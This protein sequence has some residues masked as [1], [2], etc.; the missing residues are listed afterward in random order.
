MEKKLSRHP[1]KFGTGVIEGVAAPEAANN[2]AAGGS[3]VPLL[4]L[5]IPSSGTSAVLLGALMVH[6][7]KP[8]PL[9][10]Q[11][12]PEFVWGLIASMYIAKIMLLVLNLPL[13]GLWVQMLRIPYS[14]LA[15]CIV[16]ICAIG[17]YSMKNNIDDV[18]M[19]ILFGVLGYILRKLRFELGPILLAFV[20][21]RILE[22]SLRQALLI[23]RG[24]VT[25]FLTKPI[26]AALLGIAAVM[27]LATLVVS[28]ARYLKAGRPT[29]V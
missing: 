10:F 18:V 2:A 12:S 26:S 20:L 4:A 21:G 13:V 24:D 25:I 27:I 11:T 17:V 14:I 5:G 23:S 6:G 28:M 9:L 1:E 22:R 8:G 29:P 3:M 15:P 7:L 19:M 16:L